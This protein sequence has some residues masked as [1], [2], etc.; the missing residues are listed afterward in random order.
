MIVKSPDQMHINFSVNNHSDIR[1]SSLQGMSDIAQWC[2][3]AF[4]KGY[5]C[6]HL[7]R[8]GNQCNTN[9]ISNQRPDFKQWHNVSLIVTFNVPHHS[10]IGLLQRLYQPFFKSVHYCSTFP[11]EVGSMT[12]DSPL[13]PLIKPLNVI[14]VEAD[15][16]FSG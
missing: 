13:F 3:L 9:T 2:V 4:E 14:N 6:S 11:A 12:Q 5:D 7:C 15:E 10:Y 1:P 16:L 8:K